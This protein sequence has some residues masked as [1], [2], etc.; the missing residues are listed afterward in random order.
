MSKEVI[1]TGVRSNDELTLGNYLGVFLPMVDM[2]KK[3][4]GKY[5]INMF[6]PDLHS[7]T[8]PV[9]YRALFTNTL[10]NLNF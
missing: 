4:A 2:A 8:V 1:L 10:N 7:F 9:D 6:V 5:Q 3:H